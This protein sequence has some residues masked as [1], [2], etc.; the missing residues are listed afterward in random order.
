MMKKLKRIVVGLDVFEK[1][2]D[3]LKRALALA[4]E[5]KADLFIVHAVRIPWLAVPSYFGS[6]DIAID[7][8]GITKKIEKKVKALN[9][10][11]KVSCFI[12]VKEGN[13]A[14]IILYESKLNQADMI[15]IG[16]HSREKGRKGFV[17]TTAQK[18]AHQSHLPVLI[19]NNS[20]KN[21]YKNIIAP[22]DFEIQSKQSVLFAKNIFPKAKI[23]IVHAFETIYMEGPYAVAGRDLSQYNDVAKSCAKK[24]LK[25]FM[26]D[27]AVKSGKIIDGELYTKEALIDYIKE[28]AYDL[29]VVGSRGTAG[30]NALLGS[31]ATYILRESSSDVLVYVA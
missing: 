31:V 3:V 25:D 27:V 13:A 6:K 8:E 16:K 7:K 5:H 29:V 21:T 10:D 15:V 1:S 23:K 19:V 2:N 24:D 9:K 18:V 17:G 22:T 30:L 4:N 20:A 14:D 28:G 12:F 11:F 26:K